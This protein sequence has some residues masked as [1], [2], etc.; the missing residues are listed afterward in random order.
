M[1][2][3]ISLKVPK[4][5]PKSPKR[6]EVYKDVKEKETVSLSKNMIVKNRKGCLEKKQEQQNEELSFSVCKEINKEL[7]I[8][9]N[10]AERAKL[11]NPKPF[12]EEPKAESK[13]IEDSVLDQKSPEL[14]VF[15]KEQSPKKSLREA[16]ISS[17]NFSPQSEREKQE[18]NGVENPSFDII[19][20]FQKILKSEE[21]GNSQLSY[22]DSKFRSSFMNNSLNQSLHSRNNESGLRSS[23]LRFGKIYQH[24][25]E[26][27]NGMIEELD[28]EHDL[29]SLSE[30]SEENASQKIKDSDALEGKIQ[31]NSIFQSIEVKMIDLEGKNKEL[32][33]TG[34]KSLKNEF[35]NPAA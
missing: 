23:R 30:Y 1:G 2:I 24:N 25:D 12:L 11:R 3:C 31:A 34:E 28:S 5:S 33:A 4:K 14:P 8:N 15:T 17:R 9:Q 6:K 16:P 21:I 27:G 7:P 22:H 35:I 19:S 18:D 26:N 32:R 20:N 29:Q 13:S 10:G